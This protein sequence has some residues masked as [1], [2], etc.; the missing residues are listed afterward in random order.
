MN[1]FLLLFSLT[2]ALGHS[3]KWNCVFLIMLVALFNISLIKYNENGIVV[4]FYEVL[5]L[6]LLNMVS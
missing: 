2:L 6:L 3:F 4:G 5:P 1:V